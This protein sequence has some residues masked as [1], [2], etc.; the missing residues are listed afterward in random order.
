MDLCCTTRC[1][2]RKIGGNKGVAG[3][4]GNT[5]LPARCRP[6][7]IGGNL[8]QHGVVTRLPTPTA[9]LGVL[10]RTPVLPGR[11]LDLRKPGAA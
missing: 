3:L 11:R 10:Y 7:I 6:L 1:S 4:I 9:T 8:W 5:V 2:P